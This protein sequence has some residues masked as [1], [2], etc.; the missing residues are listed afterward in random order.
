MDVG[1][2][3]FWCFSALV[4]VKYS[5]TVHLCPKY[6]SRDPR[7]H[8]S[9]KINAFAGVREHPWPFVLA[10]FSAVPCHHRRM[11]AVSWMIFRYSSW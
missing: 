6:V 10:L 5:V 2:C 1:E 3:W 11:H 9:S 7:Q 8:F 4:H